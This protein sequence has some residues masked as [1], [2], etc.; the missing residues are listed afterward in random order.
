MALLATIQIPQLQGRTRWLLPKA[1]K[2]VCHATTRT[3][4]NTEGKR[5][6]DESVI[7]RKQVSKHTCSNKYRPGNIGWGPRKAV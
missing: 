6:M 5:G 2:L 1:T 4:L 7:V 3:A